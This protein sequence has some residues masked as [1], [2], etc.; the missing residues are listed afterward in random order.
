MADQGKDD[1]G[2]GG[3][4]PHES[5]KRKFDDILAALEAHKRAKKSAA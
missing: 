3:E 4:A 2:G 5:A 1:N